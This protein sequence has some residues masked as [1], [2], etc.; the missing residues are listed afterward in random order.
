MAETVPVHHRGWLLV[1]LG[2]FGTAAGFLVA[3][4]AAAILE[5]LFSWRILWMLGLPT[6]LLL[7]I[8]NRYIPESPRYLASK[9]LNQQARDVLQRFCGDHEHDVTAVVTETLPSSNTGNWR[10]LWRAPYSGIT[11][12]LIATGLAWGLVNFG[13]LLWLPTNLR[14]TGLDAQANAIIAQ[15]ALV[16]LPGVLLVVWLYH[17]WSCIRS[18]VLFI[19][20]TVVSLWLVCLARSL[21]EESTTLL[22]IAIALLLVNASGV[23]AMLVPYASEIFPVHLRG[24]GA[25][26]VAGSSKAGGIIGALLGVAGLWDNLLMAVTIITVAAAGSALLLARYGIDTRRLKLENIHGAILRR[27]VPALQIS[28]R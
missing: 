25:G 14:A 12:G 17:S 5:P 27:N 4:G 19:V 7:I 15:S 26:M 28:D 9:G 10:E 22:G 23:I 16:A 8:L 20:L 11:L 2:G 21:V 1:A 24:T 3:S 18:L 6:G 13:F